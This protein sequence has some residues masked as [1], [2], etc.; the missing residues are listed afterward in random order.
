MF[1]YVKNSLFVGSGPYVYLYSK[2]GTP[3][4]SDAGFEEWAT[5]P[6]VTTT[7]TVP[8]PASVWGGLALLGLLVVTKVRAGFRHSA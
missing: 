7:S 6:A 4:A 5:R 2:F 1:A 3:D 8:L